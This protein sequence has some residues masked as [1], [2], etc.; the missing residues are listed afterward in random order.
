MKIGNRTLVNAVPGTF[1]TLAVTDPLRLAHIDDMFDTYVVVISLMLLLIVVNRLSLYTTRLCML[2]ASACKRASETV[3]MSP[4]TDR[5]KTD[6]CEKT[7][8]RQHLPAR[9]SVPPR[10]K[11]EVVI[12]TENNDS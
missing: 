10:S 12:W 2:K 11:S 9:D 7:K 4:S 6:V 5:Q 1:K 3:C 8:P